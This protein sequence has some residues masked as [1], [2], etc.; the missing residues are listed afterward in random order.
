MRFVVLF[1]THTLFRGESTTLLTHF[2][3]ATA[4][5]DLATEEKIH[6]V[7]FESCKGSTMLLIAHRIHTIMKCDR[8]L[9]LERGQML[10]FGTPE[11]L[12]QTSPD[13]A[14]LIKHAGLKAGGRHSV[15]VPATL[16]L[17]PVE[18][19]A[20]TPTATTLIEL[21]PEAGTSA[22]AQQ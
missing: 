13:F 9:M 8:V 21:P 19:A 4:N 22:S 6:Q 7:L 16:S 5:I 2:F 11:E 14:S 17:P 10:A 3:Q 15:S 18:A 20:T 12:V 1:H